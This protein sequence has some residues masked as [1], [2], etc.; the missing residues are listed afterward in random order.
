[1][2]N[3]FFTNHSSTVPYFDQLN[4]NISSNIFVTVW[5]EMEAS[6]DFIFFIKEKKNKIMEQK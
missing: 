3:F 2:N 5:L 6:M 1:M 4:L